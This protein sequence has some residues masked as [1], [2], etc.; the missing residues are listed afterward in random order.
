MA[1]LDTTKKRFIQDR[2][3]KIF[4]G[5]DMPFH[6]SEGTEGYFKCTTNTIDAV[7]V[8]IKNFLLTHQGERLMKPNFGNPLRNSL[9][10]QITSDGQV[11]VMKDIRDLIVRYFPYVEITDFYMNEITDGA[12]GISPSGRYDNGINLKIL[13]KIRNATNMGG[14]VNVDLTKTD[15]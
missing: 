11:K 3:E 13:F 1:V 9:F 12:P 15:T 6:K 10:E 7:K 14:T 2:D 4:I 8:N 5:I